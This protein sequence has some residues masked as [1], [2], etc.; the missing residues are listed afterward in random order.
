MVTH[1]V[2]NQVVTLATLGEI[3]LGVINDPICATRGGIETAKGPL[4][5]LTVTPRCDSFGASKPLA[6]PTRWKAAL[7]LSKGFGGFAKSSMKKP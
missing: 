4:R 6:C 2:E 7:V 3:L 5:A 1:A